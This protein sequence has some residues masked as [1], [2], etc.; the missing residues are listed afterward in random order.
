VNRKEDKSNAAHN[1]AVVLAAISAAADV[2]A[3]CPSDVELMALLRGMATKRKVNETMVILQANGLITRAYMPGYRRVTIVA[4]GKSTAPFP[5]HIRGT[6]RVSKVV[7][8][9]RSRFGDPVL[10]CEREL[11][12]A[13]L[14]LWEDEREYGDHPA[15]APA[16]HAVLA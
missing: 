8:R 3:P 1:R 7:P 10:G 14:Q 13:P 4:T 2:G 12:P 15:F 9:S 6:P 16:W 5:E 11:K